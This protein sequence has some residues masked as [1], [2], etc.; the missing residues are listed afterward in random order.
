MQTI[1]FLQIILEDLQILL[2]RKE[3]YSEEQDQ[4]NYKGPVN[5]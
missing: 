5:K 4:V 3:R 2:N 1:S